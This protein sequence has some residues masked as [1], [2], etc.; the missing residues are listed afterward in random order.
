VI[1]I[2]SIML[3]IVAVIGLVGGLVYFYRKKRLGAAFKH[4][5]MAENLVGNNMEFPNQM[6]LPEE[7]EAGGHNIP[8]SESTNFANPVYETMYGGGEAAASEANGG[9]H[10]QE[11]EGLLASD[12][13]QI[14]AQSVNDHDSESVDLLT[15]KHRGNISL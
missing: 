6:F 4:R 10:H 13:D 7:D 12:P 5:R 14:D 11:E 8:M 2:M 3:S 9:H 1:T 15:E